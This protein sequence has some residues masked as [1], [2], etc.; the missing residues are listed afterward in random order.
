MYRI[1]ITEDIGPAGLALIDAAEDA[2][3]DIIHLPPRDKLIE[4]IVITNDF[5]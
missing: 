4:I 1:L 5:D 2:E 3:Y